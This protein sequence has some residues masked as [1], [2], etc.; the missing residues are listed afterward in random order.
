MPVFCAVS[1]LLFLASVALLVVSYPLGLAESEP[2]GQGYAE[3]VNWS[4]QPLF[5]PVLALFINNSWRWY[6]EAWWAIPSHGVLWKGN[7]VC[8]DTNALTVI[9][10]TLR[11]T[12]PYLFVPALLLGGLLSA[13]D[14]G[15]LWREYGVFGASHPAACIEDD[16]TVAF[17][18]NEKFPNASISSNGWFV[19]V[20]YFL[21]AGLIGYAWVVNFQLALHSYYFLKFET[22]SANPD[23]LSL[24]LNYRDPVREFGLSGINRAINITYVFIALC[25]LLPVLSAYQNLDLDLG[26]LLLR[27]FLPLVLLVPIVVPIAERITRVKEAAER[28]RRDPEPGAQDDFAKQ[29]LWPFEGTHIGL[30]GKAAALMI[31]GEYLFLFSRNFKDLWPF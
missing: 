27:I 1:V 8:T 15:C 21:Q 30:I 26:Q 25:M 20:A 29:R 2:S 7:H 10:A 14:A 22:L 4:L 31:A 23:R 5:W 13:L 6:E 9:V 18:L 3:K 11:K 28:M 17:R 24:R 16:F 12:R 19:L